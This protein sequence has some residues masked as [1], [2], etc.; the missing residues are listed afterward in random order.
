MIAVDASTWIAFLDRAFLD[1]QAPMAP[2]VLTEMLSTATS[3]PRLHRLSVA[4]L[5]SR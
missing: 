3:P 4:C 1:R 5:S 2:A